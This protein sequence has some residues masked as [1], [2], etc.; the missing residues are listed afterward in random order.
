MKLDFKLK[1]SIFFLLHIF[2]C[3]YVTQVDES[4][5]DII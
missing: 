3:K 4:H 5:I 2:V 1:L